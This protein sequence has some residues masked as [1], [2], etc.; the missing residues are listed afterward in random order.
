MMAFFL[1]PRPTVPLNIIFALLVAVIYLALS[2]TMAW[3]A[4]KQA[5]LQNLG[6][7]VNDALRRPVKDVVVTRNRATAGP[8][9]HQ[10]PMNVASFVYQQA[11]TASIR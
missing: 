10:P 4:P 11:G 5:T 9:H 8:W 6:G 7:T 3:A 1:I 2:E